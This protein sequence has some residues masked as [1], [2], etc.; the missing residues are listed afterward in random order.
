MC[1]FG[2][3][4]VR[5]LKCVWGGVLVCVCV[6]H[7]ENPNW[8]QFWFCHRVTIQS[9]TFR[10]A[11]SRSHRRR[12][13]LHNGTLCESGFGDKRVI[14]HS[15]LDYDKCS[16][17]KRKT[18]P[19][20]TL[21]LVMEW[22]QGVFCLF[23]CFFLSVG[24]CSHAL[25]SNK[26]AWCSSSLWSCKNVLSLYSS[27][28]FVTSPLLLKAVSVVWWNLTSAQVR[29]C[30]IMGNKCIGHFAV[31]STVIEPLVSTQSS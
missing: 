20:K 10:M 25:L 18:P 7:L 8:L 29:T 21:T 2:R 28:W 27:I 12:M 19:W 6:Q 1:Q 3:R 4:T 26:A 31:S 5:L 11:E 14:V 16:H 23:V 30:W 13:L 15:C 22:R 24:N 9:F 17:F